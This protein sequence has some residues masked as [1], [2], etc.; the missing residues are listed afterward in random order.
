MLRDKINSPPTGK[1]RSKWE[2]AITTDTRE[3]KC[4]AH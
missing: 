2:D 4:N 1:L 3:I